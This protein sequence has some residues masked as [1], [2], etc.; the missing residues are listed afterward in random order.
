MLGRFRLVGTSSG[1]VPGPNDEVVGSETADG[2]S[3]T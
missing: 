1:S 2:S 3:G